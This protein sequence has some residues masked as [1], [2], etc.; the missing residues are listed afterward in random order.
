MMSSMNF[1]SPGLP[2]VLRVCTG[3]SLLAA[4]MNSHAYLDPGSG[5]IIIQALLAAAI[6]AAV[7]LKFYWLR[8]KGFLQ[9]LFSSKSANQASVDEQDKGE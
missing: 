2:N 3:I 5:S 1:I 9:R 6:S 7:T 4:S 8:V